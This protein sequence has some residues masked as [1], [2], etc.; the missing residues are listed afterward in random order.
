M[1]ICIQRKF[2]VPA[3]VVTP[4]AFEA[5]LDDPEVAHRVERARSFHAQDKGAYTREKTDCRGSSSRAVDSFP[6]NIPTR[7]V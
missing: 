6:M 2:G 3:E 7:R 1:A 4:Q 5:V